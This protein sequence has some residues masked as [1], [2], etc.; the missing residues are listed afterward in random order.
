MRGI[1]WRVIHFA[2]V[3]LT[4]LLCVGCAALFGVH[5]VS[6][7]YGVVPMGSVPTTVFRCSSNSAGNF[8]ATYD[9]ITPTG[10]C[11]WML[12]TYQQRGPIPEG[13][14][15]CPDVG[16]P[17]DNG[18]N[19]SRSVGACNSSQCAINVTYTSLCASYASGSSVDMRSFQS[20][21][22]NKA[23]C[24]D[25]STGST[26]CTCNNGFRAEGSVN[27]TC[28]PYACN[29]VGSYSTQS[30]PDVQVFT[31]D[32]HQCVGGCQV[33]ANRIEVGPDGKMWASWPFVGLGAQLFCGGVN[34]PATQKPPTELERTT[35]TGTGAPAPL[36]CKLGEA[37]GTVNG[38]LVCVKSVAG[39]TSKD[40]VGSDG[41]VT[42]EVTTCT[43][44][45]CTT[46]RV[47][48]DGTTGGAIIG[49]S[50]VEAPGSSGGGAGVGTDPMKPFCTDNPTS[51]ICK[52]SMISGTCEAVACDGDAVQCAMAREQA[53]RNCEL[54]DKATPLS[55][56][57]I[58]AT[59]AGL[60]PSDHPGAPG[61]VAS[62]GL[63]ALSDVP[64]FGSSGGCPADVTVRLGAQTVVI[65]F[66]AMCSSLAMI[67]LALKGL[68]Y[69]AAVF[70]IFRRGS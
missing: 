12:D 47:N 41:A 4:F 36:P 14:K 44:G 68:A 62:V 19:I 40:S 43:N 24:T 42:K 55:T 15:Y 21:T 56:I 16:G 61:N 22:Q 34:I 1:A 25:N 38:T 45:Q 67:G 65:P 11:D 17:I 64:L 58:A 5:G 29:A 6:W 53:K 70:I 13:Q 52:T 59:V 54:M 51:I 28:V 46:A 18:G 63:P 69:F 37:T 7:G 8:P 3:K 57:G 66:S 23:K 26:S 35:G 39:V 33:V 49:K 10:A 60:K 48:P 31:A 2:A 50:G 27:P 20:T 30:T 9:G 32:T